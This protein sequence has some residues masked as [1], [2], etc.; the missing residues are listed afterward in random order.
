VT[1][2][3]IAAA[4]LS[5]GFASPALARDG[6]RS[7][8]HEGITYDYTSSKIDDVLVLEGTARPLGGAFRLEVRNGKV[9]GYVGTTR[10]SFLV[11]DVKR[12]PLSIKV[13]T[14]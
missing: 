10:V 12:L 8:T 4:A 14:R 2:F 1:K 9:T 5:L 7:F 13:A 6:M 11:R 3:F